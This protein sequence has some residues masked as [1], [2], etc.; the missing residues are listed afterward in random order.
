MPIKALTSYRHYI[1]LFIIEMAGNRY[2]GSI[3]IASGN[4]T[5][6]PLWLFLS[7]AIHL[8]PAI[9]SV[10]IPRVPQRDFRPP[11][12]QVELMTRPEAVIAEEAPKIEGPIS[13][14]EPKAEPEVKIK[15][16]KPK[17]IKK[18]R[19]EV[20]IL[21][22]KH[23][24]DAARPNEAIAKMREKF[25]A[26]EA[27]ERIRKKVKE[28]ETAS[29]SEI[30]VAA[31][32]PAKIYHYQELDDEMKAYYAKISQIIRN[33][34]MLPDV[35]RNK[36]YK[37]VIALKVLKDGTVES[38]WI[39]QKSGNSSYDETTVRAINKV[40]TLPPLPNVWKEGAIDLGFNF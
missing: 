16:I 38:L 15:D 14:E 6:F 32:A 27:V 35:L 34:W 2:K 33:A 30:K 19:K 9:V 24:E 1:N 22:P 39:M 7:V 10:F 23:K 4:H 18:T 25:A 37:T 3:H 26:E 13:R 21:K 12:Y 36:G 40:A 5:G 20:V 8:V 17:A 28:K 29:G 31:R 11:V